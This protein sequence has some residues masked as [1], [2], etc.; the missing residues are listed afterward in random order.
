LEQLVILL[1]EEF[2]PIEEVVIGHLE[3]IADPVY[4]LLLMSDV[5]YE[6]NQ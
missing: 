1:G 3:M 4:L 2:E 6:L 5:Q